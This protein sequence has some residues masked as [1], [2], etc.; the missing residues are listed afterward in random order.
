MRIKL[1]L[2]LVIAM[3]GL[4]LVGVRAQEPAKKAE[5]PKPD[6]DGF[7]TLFNGKD[8]TGWEGL[9][10]HWS[11]KDGTI[12]GSQ[13]LEN[14]KHTFLILGASRAEPSKF[15]NFELR[16]KY[17]W[18]STGGD[19]GIQ[20]RSKMVEDTRDPTNKFKVGGYQINTV[21]QRTYDGGLYDEASVAGNRGIMSQRGFKTTWDK[22]NKRTNDPLPQSAQELLAFVHEPNTEFND[23]VFVANGGHFTITMN[24]HLMGEVIDQSPKAVLDGGL[25]AFQLHTGRAMTIQFKDVKIKFL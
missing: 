14:A 13:T 23:V 12:Q 6:A 16:F 9:E 10:D 24:G 8:L 7:I 11:V 25:I 3:I 19:S 22:D 20:F 15:A 5:L 1:T 21:P 17:K 18:L 4:S 2:V